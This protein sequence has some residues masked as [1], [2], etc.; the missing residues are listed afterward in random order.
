MFLSLSENCLGKNFW[1]AWESY[2]ESLA[3]LGK[4]VSIISEIKSPF[5]EARFTHLEDTWLFTKK[6]KRFYL[7]IFRERGRKGEREGEKH[8]CMRE[9]P[10]DCLLQGPQ[11]GT[12][13]TTQACALTG[14]K[15]TCDLWLYGI[16]LNQL[17]HFGQ[18]KI[19]SLLSFV[20][21]L[22]NLIRHLSV[23]QV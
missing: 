20:T 12:K 10:I 21:I 19:D 16:K 1:W 5:W 3:F 18:G 15:S 13:P 14:N 23:Y 11:L 8:Q 22:I 7:F 9:T 17:I 6:L 2:L 4:C